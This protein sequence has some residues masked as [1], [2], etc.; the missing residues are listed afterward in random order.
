MRKDIGVFKQKILKNNGSKA[1]NIC[2]DGRDSA[3]RVCGKAP[4]LRQNT[5]A[6]HSRAVAGHTGIPAEI[7]HI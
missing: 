1:G 2:E 5:R 4:A 7:S 3:K 6:E